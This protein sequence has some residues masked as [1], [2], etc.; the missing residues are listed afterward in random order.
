[1]ILV[2]RVV[3]VVIPVEGG[4]PVVPEVGEYF[5]LALVQGVETGKDELFVRV[6]VGEAFAE[7]ALPHALVTEIFCR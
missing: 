1:M 4:L 5:F 3:K 2:C 7:K 6:V